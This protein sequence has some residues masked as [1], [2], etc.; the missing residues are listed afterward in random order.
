MSAR[1]H[2][3]FKIEPHYFGDSERQLLG[4]YHG[5][6]GRARAHGVVLCPPAPQEYMRTHMAFRK[7]AGILSR[8]GFHVLRFDYY[9]TGDSAGGSNDGSIA[10]WQKNI[11]SAVVDLKDCSGVT[12]I[13]LIGHRLGAA[14]AARTPLTVSNLVLWEPVINGRDYLED[15]RT[16]HQRKFSDLLF[17]PRL[18]PDGLGGELLGFPLP[19]DMETEIRSLNLIDQIACRAEHIVLVASQQGTEYATFESTMREKDSAVPGRFECHYVPDE[20]GSNSQEGMLMSTQILQVMASALA[21][22]VV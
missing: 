4:I 19:K 12:K 17:P 15:L 6:S 14:L 3:G 22:R 13:S 2:L 11:A 18:P 1:G 16:I 8:D 5:P 9:G 10:E 7:V 20:S 21:R